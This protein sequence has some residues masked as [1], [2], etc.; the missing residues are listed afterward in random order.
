MFTISFGLLLI[1]T[2][3]SLGV[4][5]H[6]PTGS[7]DYWIGNI[8]PRCAINIIYHAF[9]NDFNFS[10]THNIPVMFVPLKSHNNSYSRRTNLRSTRFYNSSLRFLKAEC[11][12]SIIYYKLPQSL[13]STTKNHPVVV[14]EWISHIAYG[15]PN[16]NKYES[17]TTYCLILYH[18]NQ[19]I[20]MDLKWNLGYGREMNVA[21]I[22]L[23]NTSKNGYTVYCR[24]PDTTLQ[25]AAHNFISSKGASTVNQKFMTA[26]SSHYTHVFLN[27][28]NRGRFFDTA[29]Y[30]LKIIK[31]MILKANASISYGFETHEQYL[32][33]IGAPR[34]ILN[35]VRGY[36]ASLSLFPTF[37]NSIRI[38]TCYSPPLLSFHFYVS[39]FEKNVWT[40]IILCGMLLS[41]FLN[42]H[43]YYNLSKTINFSSWLFYFSIC[44]EESYSIPSII[45]N[46]KVFRTSTI[47]WLLTA[48]VLTNTYVS[49]VISGLN[50]T[51]LG[52]N[53]GGIKDLYGNISEEPE[54]EIQ[55]V[56]EYNKLLIMV[57]ELNSQPFMFFTGDIKLY[58][59]E[60]HH[61]FSSNK[62]NG[63]TMLSE[64]AKLPY[65]GNVWLHLQNPYMYTVFS[66][67][68]RQINNC[69]SGLVAP[70]SSFCRTLSS[71]MNPS[72]K[73]YL[74]VHTVGEIH[75]RV[76]L[77]SYLV[78]C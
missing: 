3:K 57:P 51:L 15:F 67:N 25:V 5:S 37:D 29:D 23:S 68:L 55:N 48:V 45:G 35:E 43:V 62:T 18:E 46:N 72:N 9:S 20:D 52:N 44:M 17:N 40:E 21:L 47:L 53:L 38:F 64:P 76:L 2:L 70:N 7:I 58:I 30:E 63:Y 71:L 19:S 59:E 56:K 31:Y 75:W 12:F 4:L 74:S 49:H 22:Y 50:A 27:E 34:V 6:I 16:L 13:R 42:C 77:F 69:Y 61:D 65:P 78:S 60:L 28:Y 66:S 14:Q 1:T 54:N 32:Y 33:N 8:S 73:Y 41:A 26:C 10:S 39:A 11:Y 24:T 36:F